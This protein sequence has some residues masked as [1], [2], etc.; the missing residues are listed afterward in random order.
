MIEFHKFDQSSHYPRP[1]PHKGAESTRGT[2]PCLSVSLPSL[3]VFLIFLLG[4]SSPPRSK[5]FPT[6]SFSFLVPLY[7]SSP[8]L[9][10]IFPTP[11]ISFPLLLQI[12]PILSSSIIIILPGPNISLL[13]TFSS[14]SFSLYRVS[15]GLHIISLFVLEEGLTIAHAVPRCEVDPNFRRDRKDKQ[16]KG[17]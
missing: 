17:R 16:R 7:P 6:P 4:S 11:N 3:N 2:S 13:Q 15:P 8:P 9:E 14:F 10:K 1:L 12:T 5:Y